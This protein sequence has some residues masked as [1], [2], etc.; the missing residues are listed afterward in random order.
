MLDGITALMGI[1]SSQ[2]QELGW[3]GER[4]LPSM[5]TQS[6]TRLSD[7]TDQRPRF[8]CNVT[9]FLSVPTFGRVRLLPASLLL[10]ILPLHETALC[11]QFF[12]SWIQ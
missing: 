10:V 3:T 2:L 7:R 12:A 8:R 5:G 6:W 1:S 11:T 9:N 4:V